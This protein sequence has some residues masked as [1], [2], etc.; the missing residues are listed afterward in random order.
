MKTFAHFDDIPPSA[1]YLGSEYG[2][3]SM[4]ESL[5]DAV[6]EAIY[7]ARLREDDGTFSYFDLGA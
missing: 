3:G 1:L 7:P 4:D 5:A 2:D 6:A